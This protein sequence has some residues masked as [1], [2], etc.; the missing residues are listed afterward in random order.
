MFKKVIIVGLVTGRIAF[1]KIPFLTRT[2][3]LLFET[4]SFYIVPAVLELNVQARPETCLCLQSAGTKATYHSLY[5]SKPFLE[6]EGSSLSLKSIRTS[7][8]S[9]RA[10]TLQF[11]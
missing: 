7:D 4:G 8:L 1:E 11:L 3:L 6:L 10:P 5:K 2:F 9:N